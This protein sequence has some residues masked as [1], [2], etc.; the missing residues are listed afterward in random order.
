M[1]TLQHSFP[2]LIL[3]SGEKEEGEEPMEGKWKRDWAGRS[4]A[5][6]ARRKTRK[7]LSP[8]TIADEG[9]EGS[10]GRKEKREREFSTS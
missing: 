6:A 3:R 5:I 7:I 1:I 8:L 10:G 2:F 9:E 4:I